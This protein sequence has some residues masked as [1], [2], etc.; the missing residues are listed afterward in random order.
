MIHSEKTIETNVHYGEYLLS[1]KKLLL[2][3]SCQAGLMSE[4]TIQD[5]DQSLETFCSPAAPEYVKLYCS[6][7]PA[8]SLNYWNNLIE[9][10]AKLSLL[11]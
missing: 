8:I 3:Y 4:Q 1:E 5:N 9:G 10:K 7:T 2:V 6:Y 11:D